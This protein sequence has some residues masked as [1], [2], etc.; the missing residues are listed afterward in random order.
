MVRVKFEAMVT[1]IET[2]RNSHST[3]SRYREQWVEFENTSHLPRKRNALV[4]YTIA[5]RRSHAT[6]LGERSALAGY[7]IVYGSNLMCYITISLA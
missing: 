6:H 7:G 2:S 4:G 5:Y 3:G 1:S